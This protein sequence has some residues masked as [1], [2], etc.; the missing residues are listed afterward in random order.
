M[1]ISMFVWGV[2]KHGVLESVRFYIDD[3][4]MYTVLILTHPY[5]YMGFQAYLFLNTSVCDFSTAVLIPT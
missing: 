3:L 2:I 1:E 5:Q 4:P